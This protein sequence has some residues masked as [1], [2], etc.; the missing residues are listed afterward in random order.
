MYFVLRH[1]PALLSTPVG[2]S[3]F[4]PRTVF[5]K[6]FFKAQPV[7]DFLCE[8]LALRNT[9]Y[10]PTLNDNQQSRLSRRLRNLKIEIAQVE[11]ARKYRL[12]NLTRRTAEEQVFPLQLENK[13]TVEC[14]V[15]KFFQEKY[16][17]QLQFPPWLCGS[18][19]TIT[20]MMTITIITTTIPDLS[21]MGTGQGVADRLLPTNLVQTA[22]SPCNIFISVRWSQSLSLSWT[23]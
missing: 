22:S 17:I 1:L 20:I 14:T 23:I 15:S 8:L 5:Y 16:R 2:R 21:A 10:T 9:L 12:C 11:H 18:T 19:I 7:M 6:V 13:H 4:S 3:F